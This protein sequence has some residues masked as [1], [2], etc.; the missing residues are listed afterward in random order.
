M[1]SS[2]SVC[3]GFRL[4]AFSPLS[5]GLVPFILIQVNHSFPFRIVIFLTRFELE[6]LFKIHFSGGS[7]FGLCWLK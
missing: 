2:L 3:L 7:C 1:L 5:L 4:Y 6:V